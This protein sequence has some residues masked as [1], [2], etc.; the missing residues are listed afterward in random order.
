MKNVRDLELKVEAL[1][2]RLS[3]LSNASMKIS[4]SLQFDVVL[5]GVLDSACSLTGAIYGAMVLL[6]DSLQVQNFLTSGLTSDQASRLLNIADG[7]RIFESIGGFSKPVRHPSFRTFVRELGLPEFE[8]PVEVSPQL[9]FM[10]API[11]HHGRPTGIVYL[12]DKVAGREFTVEDQETLVLFAAQAALV[13]ANAQYHHDEQQARANLQALVNTVPVGVLVFNA[14][15][16]EPVFVNQETRRISSEL[17]TSDIAAENVLKSLTIRRANGAEISL[18]QLPLATALSTGETVRAEEIV[19]NV[20]GGRKVTGLLNATPICSDDGEIES[21]VIAIQDL[22]PLEESD[23]LRAEFLG[24]VGHE[25][26]TPLAAIKGSASTLV[27]EM[28]SLDPAEA[29]QFCRIIVD[30][31]ER[32][33]NLISDLLDIARIEAGTFSVSLKREEVAELLDDARVTFLATGNTS[34][35]RVEIPQSL[36]AVMA[37]KRRIT[38]VVVNLLNN[39]AKHSSNASLIHVFA[40]LTATHVAI[41]VADDGDGI[42]NDRIPLLFR[43]FSEA[44]GLNGDSGLGLVICKGIVEAHGGRIWAESDG[45]GTGARFTFT[46]PAYETSQV[47]AIEDAEASPRGR[48]NA[49]K[50]GNRILVVDDDP[51]VLRYVRDV[52]AKAGFAPRVTADPEEVPRLLEEGDPDLALL[53]LMLPGTNGIELMK[54]VH[55][56][57]ALPVIF[58]SAYGQDD[59]ITRAFEEGAADYV[60]KPFSPTELVARIKAAL[61]KQKAGHS[62]V[63]PVEPYFVGDLGIEFKG[64]VVTLCGRPIEL[65][66]TEYRVLVELAANADR[67]VKNEEL[68]N[69]VWGRDKS[70]GSEPVRTIVK[71]LCSKLDDDANDPT[72]IFTKRRVG[73]WMPRAKR[74]E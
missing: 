1:Q 9:P 42:P 37:D 44:R 21:F 48:L 46:L 41:T 11:T 61:Q 14:K 43:R 64:Q 2:R 66:N 67:I 22:T 7:E 47:A 13:I 74:P 24:L 20:P 60:V 17:A 62:F 4:E 29:T 25:L 58:L 69:R 70:S 63:E 5:Q 3:G 36:S 73:Y 45:L 71:R 34:N 8:S 68:L 53:D 19:L 56:H 15:S 38:Q 10:C 30:Q 39:A 12:A 55:K 50:Q 23:R 6:N 49:S 35:L 28:P 54:T 65:T 33:R 59:V 32:M 40:E 16:G 26:R 31:T 57:S 72:Y 27:D 51:Q 52:V 18:N